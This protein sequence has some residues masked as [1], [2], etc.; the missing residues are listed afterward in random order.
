MTAESRT[1]RA[2]LAVV[3]PTFNERDRLDALLE[4]V[5]SALDK[6]RINAQVIVVDDNSAD[7]T[8]ERAEQWAAGGRV[9]VVHRKAKLGLGSAVMEGFAVADSDV[10]GVMDADLSHPPDLLPLLYATLVGSELDVVVASRYIPGA[11]TRQW[12]VGRRVLSRIACWLA[13]PV[14][15]VRDAT[16]GFFLVRRRCLRNF[17]TAVTG[18]K[19]GLEVLVRARPRRVAEVGYVFVGRS[20]GE[21]KLTIRE[22][23]GYLGQLVALYLAVM[24][25]AGERPGHHIVQHVEATASAVARGVQI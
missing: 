11:G 21:S 16:S 1:G 2:D 7:G 13:R 9:R 23:V 3:I 20:S 10:V 5:F 17:R 8:G 19:I 4:G 24:S 22:G 18:F 12:P 6:H 14:T 25:Q 15:P